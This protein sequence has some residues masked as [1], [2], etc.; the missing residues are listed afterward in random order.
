MNEF[1]SYLIIRHAVSG[2]TRYLERHI[3]S[4]GEIDQ[5][6]REYLVKHLRGEIIRGRGNQRTFTNENADHKLMWDISSKCRINGLKQNAAIREYL[7]ENP[8]ANED[9]V[10]S[11]LKRVRKLYPKDHFDFRGD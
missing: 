5:H 11:A 3:E 10:K 1:L 7:D 8:N 4:G 6:I 2:D 9:T